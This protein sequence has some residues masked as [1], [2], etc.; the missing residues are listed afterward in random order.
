MFRP[1]ALLMAVPV[2]CFPLEKVWNPGFDQS[3]QMWLDYSGNT[4]E[5]PNYHPWFRRNGLTADQRYAYIQ[6]AVLRAYQKGLKVIDIPYFTADPDPTAPEDAG[7]SEYLKSYVRASRDW[8]NAVNAVN[9]GIPNGDYIKLRIRINA[10]YN[11][12]GNPY[13]YTFPQ[14]SRPDQKGELI[15]AMRQIDS[16]QS[17]H[18]LDIADQGVRNHIIAWTRKVLN[19]VNNQLTDRTM[20]TEVSLALSGEGESDL[21]E[22]SENPSM[23]RLKTGWFPTTTPMF[24]EKV[25]FFRTRE[26]MLNLMYKDFG[27]AVNSFTASRMSGLKAGV[28]YQNWAFD[29]R[30][31]G[32]F[33]LYR[34]L[35]GTGIARLHFTENPQWY[36]H[37]LMF[38]A[39]SASIAARLG[40]KF[41]TEFSWAHIHLR[42]QDGSAGIDD[43]IAEN[44]SPGNM[45]RYDIHWMDVVANT[46]QN[47]TP[48][49][50][51]GTS[52]PQLHVGSSNIRAQR[53]FYQAQAGLQYGATSVVWANWCMRDVM[54]APPSP[55]WYNVI[56]GARPTGSPNDSAWLSAMKSVAVLPYGANR[57]AMYIGT[58][59]RMQCEE[60]KAIGGTGAAPCDALTYIRWFYNAG[61]YY[62]ANSLSSPLLNERIDIITD[63]MLKDKGLGILNSYGT[64]FIPYETS[65]LVDADLYN[66]LKYFAATAA[67]KRQTGPNVTATEGLQAWLS[68]AAPFAQCGS[69][70][71]AFSKGEDI[72]AHLYKGCSAGDANG[73]Y[74]QQSSGDGLAGNSDSFTFLHQEA[75]GDQTLVARI[76]SL[77]VAGGNAQAGIM[78]R[79]GTGANARFAAMMGIRNIGFRFV[80]RA[81]DGAALSPTQGSKS[82]T[83]PFYVRLVKSGN[84]ITGSTSPDGQNWTVSGSG[85][86]AFGTSFKAGLASAGGNSERALGVA[87]YANV[88]LVSGGFQ[89]QDI[90]AVGIAGAYGASGGT[91]TLKASGADIWGTADQFR[92]SWIKLSGNRTITA[93]V[94]SQQNT[95]AWAKAGVMIRSGLADGETY[96]FMALTPSSGALFQYRTAVGGTS[97][98]VQKTGITA[99]YWVR[100]VR[101]NNVL[102]GY[103]SADGATWTLVGSQAIN[104][105]LDAYV[106]LAGCGHINTGTGTTTF[107]NVSAP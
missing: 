101:N 33:D 6:D 29:S 38:T 73:G 98:N 35:Q 15:H 94:A 107:T 63:A 78:F 2:V 13:N 30:L 5:W 50:S 39:Y 3:A 106:G 103:V 67:I 9:A 89:S 62:D 47:Y 26:D 66:R 23:L 102:T 12:M 40:I 83:L 17:G 52:W 46:L 34:M 80:F 22:P 105:P 27:A 88:A 20:V 16:Q 19:A 95:H 41:D 14:G 90:G 18:S 72:G 10:Q 57:K 8:I 11:F 59:G 99:P 79:A 31:R 81:S 104:L 93:K 25:H 84:V 56:G 37:S 48:E 4:A 70:N 74:V 61:W 92:F 1:L 44:I 97:G 7:K 100:L 49:W 28:F 68:H 51:P 55:D 71:G 54:D 60:E 91:H 87:A 53:F 76:A 58:V 42:N 43:N 36:A 75:N 86:V 24:T 77:Q 82:L 85:T 64:V 96:G 32:G 65:R 45:M 69:G 21:W